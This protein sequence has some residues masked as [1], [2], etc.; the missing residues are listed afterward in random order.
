M[1]TRKKLPRQVHI[2]FV[3]DW[4]TG[5]EHNVLEVC[6]QKHGV[7]Y[8]MAHDSETYKE[9]VKYKLRAHL[10]EEELKKSSNYIKRLQARI[11]FLEEDEQDE[12]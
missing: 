3:P 11:D 10:L 1:K 2:R 9:R 12:I 8:V 6:D 5:E 7:R 4:R